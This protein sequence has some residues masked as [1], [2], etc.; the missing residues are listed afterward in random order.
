MPRKYPASPEQATFE[1]PSLPPW[2]TP[3]IKILQN[4]PLR[5]GPLISSASNIFETP[6]PVPTPRVP[7]KDAESY[8]YS[9]FCDKKLLRESKQLQLQQSEIAT[10][11]LVFHN[12]RQ[13]DPILLRPDMN[14]WCCDSSDD[15]H[16]GLRN[17]DS[18]V[19]AVFDNAGYA[20][21]RELPD[22]KPSRR[23]NSRKP[24]PN[25]ALIKHSLQ[26]YWGSPELVN[27]LDNKQLQDQY[28]VLHQERQNMRAV[29]EE[30]QSRQE[31]LPVGR[32]TEAKANILLQELERDESW[33]QQA[34]KCRPNA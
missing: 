31:V 25:F 27:S 8:D 34:G 3:R 16:E 29:K 1:L 17:D 28:H 20:L 9:P 15:E 24:E 32:N 7:G 21:S 10:H 6:Q 23:P 30:L 19:P 2:R 5:R 13:G 14:L 4:T 22:Y 12:A 33:T 26:S 18:A 11:C